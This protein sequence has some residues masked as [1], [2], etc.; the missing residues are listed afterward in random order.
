MSLSGGGDQLSMEVGNE[1][2]S[3]TGI[4]DERLARLREHMA[5]AGIDAYVVPSGDPHLSEYAHPTYERRAFISS[6]TGSAGTAL[7]T[8]TSANLWTDGRYFLQAE[9][10]LNAEWTLMR[11]LQP[12]VPT[13]EEWLASNLPDG[14]VVGIDPLVCSVD[15]AKKLESALTNAKRNLRLMPLETNLVDAVWS[16]PP[17]G[18]AV[19]PDLPTGPAREM[20]LSLTG[21]SCAA[22]L[23]L[24][25]KS[26]R[27]AGADAY[28][29][30]ALDEVCWLFNL[31]GSDVPCCP[32]LQAYALVH[33][34]RGEEGG[35]VT[36]TLFVDESKVDAAPGLR[37][38]LASAGVSTAPYE[39]IMGAVRDLASTGG[40]KLFLDPERVNY[41]LYLAAGE[42]AVPK[43]SPLTLPK[44]CKNA[45]ELDGMMQAHLQDGAALCQFFAWLRRTVV[46][47]ATPLSEVEIATKLAGF[48]A[49][50]DGF[51]DLSFPTIC[52]VG[53][54]GAV[55]HYNPVASDSSM[56]RTNDGTQMMLLDS[57]GQYATG[58]TD[59]TRTIHLGEPTAWQRECFTRVLK[60]N[61][62]LDTAI[63]P[64]GTPGMA[65]DAFA[66]SALWQAGLDYMHGTGHGVGAALNVH[67][68]PQSISTK[69]ANTQPLKEG[70]ICSNEPG[71][72]EQDGFGIR[73]ENLLVVQKADTPHAFN[74]KTYLGFT[75]L[76]HVPIQAS[77]MEPSLLTAKEVSWIDDYHSRVRS[78]LSPLLDPSDEGYE[79]LQ[80]VTRPLA[81]QLGEGAQLPQAEGTAA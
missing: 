71:F 15:E 52:G 64:D 69:Y 63:F 18:C 32:V 55:I 48:R 7:V 22:K 74:N 45:A 49:A 23:A 75:Q 6:F 72:Y 20:P 1:Q 79:W 81:E 78:K 37:A 38:S 50:R 4:G 5:A 76:T 44:A 62:A 68:G 30:G 19:R 25:A 13:L 66:R 41:G 40:T 17:S 34:P 12:G 9:Q 33:C 21:V 61:I 35:S 51:L 36:A 29:S 60:G 73:I 28:L 77:L 10:E 53:P 47:E 39:S 26:A 27:E 80:L 2:L 56:V 59:V 54:N 42:A 58:T 14:G 16:T 46:D 43:S 3:S 11:S 31:R 67:E 57:G 65:L 8:A 24:L 70:M